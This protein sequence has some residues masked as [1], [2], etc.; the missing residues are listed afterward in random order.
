ALRYSDLLAC[1]ACQGALAPDWS[2]GGCGSRFECAGNVPNLRLPGDARTDAVREFYQRAP[3]PGY[4]AH[5]SLSALH[6]R[7]ARSPFA[8]MLDRAIPC[9]ASIAEVGCGTGQ[10]SL[11]LAR[12]DRI[13]IGADLTRASLALG[14]AAAR[15]FG[16]DCVLFVETD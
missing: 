9:G 14:E 15:R 3:F 2:C 7:A 5:D 11:Y 12:A 10:M 6:T 8:R 1:P 16:L 13:V 4:P